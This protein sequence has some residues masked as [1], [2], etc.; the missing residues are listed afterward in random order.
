MCDCCNDWEAYSVANYTQR[1]KNVLDY[2]KNNFPNT[3]VNVMPTLD[4]TELYELSEGFCNLIHN[5]VCNC[6]IAS[7]DVRDEVR[8][9]QLEYVNATAFIC[10]S[11]EYTTNNFTAVYQPFTAK[12]Y[13]PQKDGKPDISFFALDCFHLSEKGHQAA[14]V[15]LF[16]NILE[17]FGR[18]LAYW[19]GPREKFECASPSDFVWTSRN[20]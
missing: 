13:V 18:K 19:E 5:S 3:I 2:L 16:N 9:L 15:A 20:S 11:P 8:K 14:T 17:K 7:Q 4:V 10:N 1:M 6:G 12:T